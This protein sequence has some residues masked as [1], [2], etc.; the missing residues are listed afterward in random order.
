MLA[1]VTP[2]VEIDLPVD[3]L[4]SDTLIGIRP[5]QAAE[6]PESK[7]LQDGL[8]LGSHLWYTEEGH[9][10]ILGTGQEGQ[11]GLWGHQFLRVLAKGHHTAEEVLLASMFN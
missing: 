11:G 10:V 3:R 5:Q 6:F 8:I 1:V 9:S 2:H 4:D 7:D